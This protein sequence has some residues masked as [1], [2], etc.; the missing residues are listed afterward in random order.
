[1]R[2]AI[3]FLLCI[4]L[5]GACSK[6]TAD[7]IPEDKM[8]LLLTDIHLAE[9]WSNE[10]AKDSSGR[11]LPRNDD[12]MA[13]MYRTIYAHHGVTDSLYRKSMDWYRARP[14]ELD[15]IYTRMV[16]RLSAMETPVPR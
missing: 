4:T 14:V 9:A 6:E 11:V 5:L 7:V 12:S 15:S 3:I 8:E 2:P 1:M 16:R 10:Q 13:A